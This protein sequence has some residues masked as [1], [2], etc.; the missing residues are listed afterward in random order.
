MN[1]MT[2]DEAA[3][4]C[5]CSKKT[6]ERAV[7]RG[8]IKAYRPGRRVLLDSATVVTWFKSKEIQPV[9]TTCRRRKNVVVN[10]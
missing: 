8:E 5:H 10:L 9:R 4:A 2:Y 6:L 1:L 7:K 3:A